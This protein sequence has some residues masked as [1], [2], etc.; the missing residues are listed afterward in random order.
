MSPAFVPHARSVFLVHH[1]R[2]DILG[3]PEVLARPL[4]VGEFGLSGMVG[5]HVR[6]FPRSDKFFRCD[7]LELVEDGEDVLRL[8]VLALDELN[9]LLFWADT[10]S[11]GLARRMFEGMEYLTKT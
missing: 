8:E 5:V 9:V 1:D 3:G 10:G 6:A 4:H 2:I 7:G 11:G